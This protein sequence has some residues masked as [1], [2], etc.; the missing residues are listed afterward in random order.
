MVLCTFVHA[1]HCLTQCLLFASSMCGLW[2]WMVGDVLFARLTLSIWCWDVGS[3]RELPHV[4]ELIFI[5]LCQIMFV[6]WCGV[7]LGFLWELHNICSLGF[8]YGLKLNNK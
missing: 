4:L 3:C 2:Y 7:G 1:I 8:C 5:G 6:S